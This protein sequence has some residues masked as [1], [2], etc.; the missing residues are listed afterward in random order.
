MHHIFSFQLKN[1]GCRLVK[2]YSWFAHCVMML[3][4]DL[5]D[6][7]EVTGMIT[8]TSTTTTVKVRYNFD[9][10]VRRTTTIDL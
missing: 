3:A 2:P 5:I 6:Y 4:P 8:T 7:E 9:E 10:L 1:E